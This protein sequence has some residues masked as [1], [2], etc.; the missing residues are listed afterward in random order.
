MEA[1]E[2]RAHDIMNG[3]ISIT[4]TYM[5]RAILD[6]GSFQQQVLHYRF[7]ADITGL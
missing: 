6:Q 7:D 2:E 4:K 5:L 1:E 3:K